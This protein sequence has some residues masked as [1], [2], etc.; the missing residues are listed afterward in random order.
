MDVPPWL[1]PRAARHIEQAVT[2]LASALGPDLEAAALVGAAMNPARAD[3]GQAPEVLAITT[4]GALRDLAPLARALHDPMKAGVRVRVLT[5]RELQRSCDVFALEIAEW[6]ARHAL[7]HGVEPF[8]GCE[9]SRAD[10]RRAIET[11]LRGLSRRI[12][13]R[14]LTALATDATRDDPRAALLAGVDRLVVSAWHALRLA[15]E[16]PPAEEPAILRALA[17]RVDAAAAADALVPHLDALRRGAK[18]D[19]LAALYALLALV[20]RAIDHVDSLAVEG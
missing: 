11:E 14:V 15:G 18:V 1:P 3:R 20:D 7:L 2:A 6:K 16:A 13:N 10:L 12:R 5:R 19:T 17:A 4:D 8:A 9:S